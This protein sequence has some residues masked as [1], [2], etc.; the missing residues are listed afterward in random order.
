MQDELEIENPA[1]VVSV[2][3][4]QAKQQAEV[5][6]SQGDVESKEQYVPRRNYQNTRGGRGGGGSGRSGGYPNCRGGR[7]GGRVGG[8]YQNGRSQYYDQPG[9]YYSRGYH[10]NRGRGGRGAGGNSYNNHVLGIQGG[11][12]PTEVGLGS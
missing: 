6:W 10:N 7:S 2:Q 4:E 9:N 11:H 3:Q 12:A 8:S 5:E 1:E